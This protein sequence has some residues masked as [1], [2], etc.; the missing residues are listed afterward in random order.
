MTKKTYTT[1]T[2]AMS[3]KIIQLL[4]SADLPNNI[5][6]INTITSLVDKATRLKT[7]NEDRSRLAN[8][9]PW[10]HPIVKWMYQYTWWD[11][12]MW[13]TINTTYFTVMSSQSHDSLLLDQVPDDE[14]WCCYESQTLLAETTLR[15]VKTAMEEAARLNKKHNCY[16]PL[17]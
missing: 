14:W 9:F 2:T 13:N 4:T 5:G 12:I 11:S 10:W 17:M 3:V 8:N 6:F 15:M 1:N 7:P 16:V